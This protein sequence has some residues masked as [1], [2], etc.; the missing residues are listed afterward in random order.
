MQPSNKGEYDRQAA[1]SKEVKRRWGVGSRHSTNEASNDRGGKAS[2]VNVNPNKETE[3]VHRNEEPMETKLLRIAQIAKEKPEE[4][5]NSLAHHINIETL[6]KS[7]NEMAN[8]KAA[9]NDGETKDEY[10]KDLENNLKDLI[11]RMK[12][13]AYKPQPVRRV[14]IPKPGSDKKRPLGIPSYEDKLVQSALAGILNAIYEADFLDSSNGFRPGR[15]CHQALRELGRI[16]ETKRINYIVD[17]DIKGFFE[18]VDHEWLIKFLKLRIGDPNIIRLIIRFLKAGVIESGITYDTPEGTPQGGV[19]SPILANVY[20][21]YVLDL[22]FE[23]AI[24]KWCKGEAHIIRYADDFICCFEHEREAKAFYTMLI[25]RLKQF[26]LE[27]AEDKTRILAFGRKALK[28]SEENGRGKPG[29]FDFLGFTHYCGKSQK[30]NFR[31]KR[32]TSRKKLRANLT[33]LQDWLRKN[34]TVVAKE[35]MKA[36]NR[37]LQGYYNY[38]GVTDNS[39][40]LEEYVYQVTRILYKWLNRRS[41]KKSFNWETFTKNFLR[42]YP[43][44]KPRIKVNLIYWLP[45]KA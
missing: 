27:I 37:K 36:L 28:D 20:L 4:R 22:W 41:Q 1:R 17:A 19:I 18:H 8:G 11:E 2:D 7:H 6:K 31:V 3:V 30:G 34:R 14:Y 35:L 5:F 24:R 16:I 40:R 25:E 42:Q 44:A 43:L 21:H 26:N 23:K 45:L 15:G 39:R 32:K 33:R 12:R 13:Q 29:T 9:G 38:Y 10:G